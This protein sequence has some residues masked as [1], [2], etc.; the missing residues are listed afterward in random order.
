MKLFQLHD[1][2]ANGVLEEETPFSYDFRMIFEGGAH[3]DE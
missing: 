1:L 3:Q 2:K